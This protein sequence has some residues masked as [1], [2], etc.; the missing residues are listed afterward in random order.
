MSLIRNG[1]QQPQAVR[2]VISNEP[3]AKVPSVQPLLTVDDAI[4]LSP[5]RG[6]FSSPFLAGLP[7]DREDL[8]DVDET[9][10]MDQFTQRVERWKQLRKERDMQAR[11]AE[12][13][14][15]P[16][17][18]LYE[19]EEPARPTRHPQASCRALLYAPPM[20]KGRLHPEFEDFFFSIDGLSMCARMFS[21]S[22]LRRLK[23]LGRRRNW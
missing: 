11:A 10:T 3:V 8:M 14:S 18:V 23:R 15:V 7:D 4:V 13:Q 5:S 19:P 9:D 2:R 22:G 20:H 21:I 17:I 1:R 12:E 6:P 16:M